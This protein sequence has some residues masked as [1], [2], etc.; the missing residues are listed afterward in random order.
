VKSAKKRLRCCGGSKNVKQQ[1]GPRTRLPSTHA[2]KQP[3]N[4]TTPQPP[5]FKHQQQHQQQQ[6]QQ[7]RWIRRQLFLNQPPLLL[8]LLLLLPLGSLCCMRL[9]L[10]ALRETTLSGRARR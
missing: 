1:A 2:P 6:Q 8:L 3:L 7:R 10:E 5:P 9:T 4:Q